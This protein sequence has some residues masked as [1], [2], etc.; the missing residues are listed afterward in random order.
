MIQL[1]DRFKILL[2]FTGIF[3]LI[4]FFPALYRPDIFLSLNK[5][6]LPGFVMRLQQINPDYI[7]IGNSML[8]SRINPEYLYALTGKK[9][10]LL[11]TGGAASAAWYLMLKNAVLASGVRPQSVI[12][13][14][15]DTF[16]TEPAYRTGG[17]YRRKIKFF[18]TDNETV[19]DSLLRKDKSLKELC[20]DRLTDLYPILDIN[21]QQAAAYIS[22]ACIHSLGKIF[23]RGFEISQVNALLD[24]S[25]FRQSDTDGDSAAAE[26]ALHYNFTAAL[27]GSF[28]PHM[29]KLAKDNHVQ[30]VFIRVQRRPVNNMPPVQST[31]LKQYIKE[32]DSYLKQENIVFHDF[33]GDPRIT[34]DMYGTGDHIDEKKNNL[35]TEIFAETLRGILK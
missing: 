12:F 27:P 6:D 7:F 32:L 11:W 19:L 25:N 16:L 30:L 10:Y 15:R 24:F 17:V 1:P 18:S 3:L 4:L 26:S 14:F 28:L 29:I 31:A 9:S 5:K 22:A 21:S 20:Y 34:L 23:S 35:Y 13:F 8:G 33:N 2:T